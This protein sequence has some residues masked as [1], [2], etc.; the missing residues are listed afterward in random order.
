SQFFL[1][2]SIINIGASSLVF[3]VVTIGRNRVYR[4][5]SKLFNVSEIKA[6]E[7]IYSSMINYKTIIFVFN[8]IP[9]IA[10]QIIK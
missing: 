8:I 1:W 4:I 5:H 2:C 10:I 9:Y 6:A 7:A 3:L